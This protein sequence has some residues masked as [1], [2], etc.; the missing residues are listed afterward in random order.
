MIDLSVIMATYKDE[1]IFLETCIESVL[2]QTYK[3][4]NFVIVIE[5]DETNIDILRRAETRDNRVQ[6][7]K[8]DSRLGIASSRNRAILKSYDKYIAIID[9][10]D[11]C[12]PERF[13]KQIA[14]LE[15]NPDV[16]VVGS[17]MYLVDRDSNIVGQ[18][19]YPKSNES[20][21]RYFLLTMGIANPSVMVRRKDMEEVGLFNP[22]LS[23]AEDMELWLRFLR[24]G[25]K[26]HNLQENLVYY[27]LPT[28]S[29]SKRNKLHM[30]NI[31][32]ARKEHS[33]F[34]WNFPERILSLLFWFLVNHVPD[35]L[36][37]YV[38]SLNVVSRLRK[39]SFAEP[40]RISSE[41]KQ[42]K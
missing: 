9:G 36:I 34:I 4:F 12:A 35:S 22:K 20:I 28:G 6:V 13:E 1:P 31:Y 8:N 38:L 7:L 39:Y 41:L 14:F 32:S 16:N 2:N 30:Q 25:K 42:P 37:D 17:N 29:N 21:E 3:N 18:R 40:L 11:Y 26:M 19:H 33:K 5:P 23:K 24:N 27:R 10:D 15:A